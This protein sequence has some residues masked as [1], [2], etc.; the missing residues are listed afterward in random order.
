LTICWWVAVADATLLTVIAMERITRQ[1]LPLAALLN[2][3]LAFPDQA[4]RRFAVARRVGRPRDLQH[5]L[6]EAR[7]AH[8]KTADVTY[9]QTI[10]ELIA[11]L[12]VFD[13]RT[14]GHVDR[15]RVFTEII[16]AE[17]HLPAA[18]RAR[19]RWAAMLHDI[20]KL[21][22]PA[23]VFN[24]R[25]SLNPA[26]WEVV[27]RHPEEGARLIDPLRPWLGPWALAVEHHHERWDGSGYPHGLVGEQISLGGRI[28]A[29]ADAFETMTTA[30]PYQRPMSVTAARAELVRCAGSQFDPGVVRALLNV[31]MGRCWRAVGVASLVAQFPLISPIRSAL[32]QLSTV[33]PSAVATGLAALPLVLTMPTAAQIGA[34]GN[35]LASPPSL[36]AAAT[37]PASSPGASAASS[38]SPQPQPADPTATATPAPASAPPSVSAPARPSPPPALAQPSPSPSPTP[39]LAPPSA[40]P[41]P[42]PALAPPSAWPSPHQASPPPWRRPV[43]P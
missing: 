3:S 30:R 6:E 27:R 39:T 38:P 41:S 40:R 20:G 11:A 25:G 42:T 26:E 35:S 22:V 21:T 36:V 31:S 7:A 37:L 18:D 1:L 16:A 14:R 10:L 12:G 34:H 19:L 8:G 23:E 4:P 13:Q 15:V 24:K 2:L 17:M 32:F 29:V 9:M 28:V 43:R 33:A 5:Q